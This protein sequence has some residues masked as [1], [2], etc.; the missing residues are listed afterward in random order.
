MINEIKLING[1]CFVFRYA[2]SVIIR[3][4]PNLL[5]YFFC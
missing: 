1:N 3:K 5:Y 4:Y 2:N